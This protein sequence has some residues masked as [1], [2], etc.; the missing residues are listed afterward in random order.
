MAALFRFILAA[1]ILLLASF[2]AAENGAPPLTIALPGFVAD[3]PA[4][5]EIAREIEWTILNDLKRDGA[6]RALRARG[7][8]ALTDPPVMHYD[9]PP[10]GDAVGRPPFVYWRGL[11][12][13]AILSGR[14]KR[15]GDGRLKVEARLWDVARGELLS[16]VQY[17][18]EPGH[19][20][21]LGHIIADTIYTRL[22]GRD[23][24]FEGDNPN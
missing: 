20:S 5:G 3:D 8:F 4:D 12:A 16:G 24:R 14:L 1:S 13:Q 9:A 6:F 10:P 18:A 21:L 22:A 7:Q 2:A 23:G 17:F 11:G 19:L 15:Q